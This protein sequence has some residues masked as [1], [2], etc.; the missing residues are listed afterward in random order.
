MNLLYV[1]GQ[2][3]VLEEVSEVRRIWLARTIDYKRTFIRYREID[4]IDPDSPQKHQAILKTFCRTCDEMEIRATK[5]PEWMDAYVE[6]LLR[7]ATPEPELWFSQSLGPFYVG[8]FKPAPHLDVVGVYVLH[9]GRWHGIWLGQPMNRYHD[10]EDPFTD[11]VQAAHDKSRELMHLM[12]KSPKRF[13]LEIQKLLSQASHIVREDE[14]D[15]GVDSLGSHPHRLDP[16][17]PITQ[18]LSQC[19]KAN[20]S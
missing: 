6:R 20:A 8:H 19:E 2:F 3:E 17:H 13:R 18:I 10:E 4:D 15:L 11:A 14:I 1:S 16:N 12:Q 7:E 9:E 5:N